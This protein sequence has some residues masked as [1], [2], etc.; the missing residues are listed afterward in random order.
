M[1]MGRPLIVVGAG[2]YWVNLVSPALNS[3]KDSGLISKISTVDVQNRD[4]TENSHVVREKNE[5]LSAVV[6]RIGYENPIVLLAHSNELHTPEAI[7]LMQNSRAKPSI[8]IEKP[9]S[10][11]EDQIGKLGGLITQYNNRVGLLEYYLT[12]KAVPLLLF[13]GQVREDSF[14]FENNGILRTKTEGSVLKDFSGKFEEMIGKPLFVVSE[15]LEGEGSYGTV[16]HRNLS[17]VDK[18]LGGGMIQDLGHH[19]LTPLIGLEAHLGLI[20]KDSIKD[21]RVAF[22]NEYMEFAQKHLPKSN[23]GESYAEIDIETDMG[24]PVRLAMGKYIEEGQNQ[25]KVLIAGTR[26]SVLYD[27]TNNLLS[28]QHGDDNSKVKPLVEADKKNVPKYLA[29]LRAGIERINGKNPFYF[30]PVSVA[31]RAQDIVLSTL[32]INPRQ[33]KEYGRGSLHDTIF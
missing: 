5:P 32:K 26:G 33:V 24:V 8:L 30:D 31:F 4:A 21:V 19:A 18:S 27:M 3:L 25:R 23:I 2:S 29:V 10:I 13:A 11:S 15:I 22:C 12:M 7:E 20:A 6:D 14:Y 17:I 1:K 16:E 9:Y 28:F